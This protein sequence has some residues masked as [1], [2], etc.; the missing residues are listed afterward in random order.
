MKWNT[1]L[2]VGIKL[3]RGECL[4]TTY[5]VCLSTVIFD[6]TE[7]KSRPNKPYNFPNTTLSC[8]RV[9]LVGIYDCYSP[10]SYTFITNQTNTVVFKHTHHPPTASEDKSKRKEK[11]REVLRYFLLFIR[12]INTV[13]VPLNSKIDF[14]VSV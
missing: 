5:S 6:S 14:F 4:N 1:I 3:D 9:T 12:I 8:L 7:L 2:S 11:G 10:Q 13:K